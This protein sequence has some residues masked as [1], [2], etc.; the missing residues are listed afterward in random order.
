[1]SEFER[2]WGERPRGLHDEEYRTTTAGEGPLTTDYSPWAAVA[3]G[4]LTLI[5]IVVT[6]LS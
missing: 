4:L 2:R 3:V 6:V 5:L 1:M